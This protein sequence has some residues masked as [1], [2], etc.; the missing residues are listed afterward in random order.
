M[1]LV[2]LEWSKG[3][4]PTVEE[5]SGDSS[6]TQGRNGYSDKKQPIKN[7]FTSTQA[8]SRIL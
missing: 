5:K 3:C 6:P 2:S 4:F 1:Q 8:R 7:V